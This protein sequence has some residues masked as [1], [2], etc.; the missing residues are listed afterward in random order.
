MKIINVSAEEKEK[1]NYFVTEH[2][3]PVGAFLQSFEWGEFK[4]TLNL[5][6][7]RYALVEKGRWLA[8]FQLEIH[9]LP[10]GLQYAYAPRGPLFR[11]DIST[12]G[13]VN[14]LFTFIASYIQEKYRSYIF[15]RFEPPY[16]HVLDCYKVKPFKVLSYYLQ[17]KYNQIIGAE[18]TEEELLKKMSRDIKHDIRAAERI[19]VVVEMKSSLDQNEK[20]AFEVMKSDTKKRSGKNIFP[21]DLYFTNLINTFGGY[22]LSNNKKPSLRFFVANKDGTP[23]AIYVAIF[24]AHT[25]T[26]LYGASYSGTVSSRAPA[27]LH[28]RAI[29][30]SHKEGFQ[31][32]DLGGVDKALWPGL[33]YFKQQYGGE[34]FEY[35]GTIDIVIRPILYRVY[36]FIKMMLSLASRFKSAV[37]VRLKS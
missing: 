37:L 14:T 28:F 34:T 15:V 36:A 25:A 26:Y 18:T 17:P 1:W 4:A 13:E 23:V 8:C 24:F 11:K 16:H 3:P 30:G 22:K 7:E 31:Y 21:S 5:K 2:F 6:I 33:T 29:T 20:L 27:Y 35:I 9:T 32:Y 19:G 12:D 10:F